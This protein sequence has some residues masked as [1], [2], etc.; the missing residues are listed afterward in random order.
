MLTDPNPVNAKSS[1]CKKPTGPTQ[2]AITI[3]LYL[4]EC[5]AHVL[6]KDSKLFNNVIFLHGCGILPSRSP[7]RI[8]F[9]LHG[10]KSMEKKKNLFCG[11]CW[12]TNRQNWATRNWRKKNSFL[13]GM[14]AYQPAKLRDAKNWNCFPPVRIPPPSHYANAISG[15][16]SNDWQEKK[17]SLKCDAFSCKKE[18]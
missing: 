10:E 1:W 5:W 17:K 4:R 13:R 9:A 16:D 18:K 15:W 6:H 3:P 8:S 7:S 12:H 14:L 2:M 11:E